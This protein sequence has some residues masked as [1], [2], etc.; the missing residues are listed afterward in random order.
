MRWS[1]ALHIPTSLYRFNELR[2]SKM[3]ARCI[4]IGY[5]LRHS[6]RKQRPSRMQECGR[7]RSGRIKYK[8]TIRH[9]HYP[10]RNVEP[11]SSSCCVVHLPESVASSDSR[12]SKL[13]KPH[14]LIMWFQTEWSCAHYACTERVGPVYLSKMTITRCA[15]YQ[16][17]SERMK[18]PFRMYDCASPMGRRSTS[19]TNT[20]MLR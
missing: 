9:T 16:Q 17:R 3:M 11:A 6:Q 2:L 8:H 13:P 1:V 14:N 5:E 12:S 4:R 7:P 19:K 10:A 18:W 15:R 20:Y